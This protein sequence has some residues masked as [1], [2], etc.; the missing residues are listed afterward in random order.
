MNLLDTLN[1]TAPLLTAAL[2]S[3]A[4]HTLD[5]EWQHLTRLL[6]ALAPSGG[7]LLPGAIGGV[8]AALADELGLK[9]NFIPEI[10]SS[11]NPGIRIGAAIHEV[12]VV[13][14]AHIDRPSFRV[15]DVSPEG[16]ELYPIC[17]D[18]FPEG[19]YRAQALAMRWEPGEGLIVGARGTFVAQ[20]GAN[21][22]HYRFIN[23]EGQL[24]YYDVV[25]LAATPQ[26]VDGV[27]TATGLDNCLGTLSALYAARILKSAEGA[28]TAAGHRI[29][30]A[31]TDLEEGVPTA[32]FGHGAARLMSALPQ[33]RVGAIVCDAQSVNAG[34][35]EMGLGAS[36]GT[37]SAWG[38]GSYAPPNF[39]RL[40]V[41][42]AAS[43]NARYPA[44]V[45]INHGYQ[46]RSDD[47]GLSRWTRVL[48][49]AGPPMINAHTA[50]E[51]AHLSDVPRTAA[52]L[53]AFTL[54][55]IQ[56]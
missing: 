19:E 13:I 28:L 24:A 3:D 22:D 37:A 29:V 23:H 42:L 56:G 43:V 53:A 48:G 41:D 5:R 11:G 46:S 18:R 40:A 32:F 2:Q 4:A 54:G 20:K 9:D 27:M 55:C 12:D 25:T 17:A 50:E 8:V 47:L 52:W 21:G 44:T 16:G 14:T 51:M 49:M 26:L 36:H 30:I 33:P 34:I 35:N 15:R 38:R 10:G 31:F 39:H 1:R 6:N 45:Q 7:C